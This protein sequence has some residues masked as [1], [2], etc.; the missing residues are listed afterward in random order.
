MPPTV[1]ALVRDQVPVGAEPV[2]EGHAAAQEGGAATLVPLHIRDALMDAVALRLG[3]GV[4]DGEWPAIVRCC[5]SRLLPSS[6]CRAVDT[7]GFCCNVFLRLQAACE[8]ARVRSHQAAIS[9]SSAMK[10]A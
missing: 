8:M 4:Q 6:A 1:L 2:A 3:H 9:N 7:R 10:A 5:T